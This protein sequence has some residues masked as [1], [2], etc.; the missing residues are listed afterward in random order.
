MRA[1]PLAVWGHRLSA[2]RLAAAARADCRLTH[3]NQSCQVSKRGKQAH[4]LL[5]AHG[6]GQSAAF[7]SAR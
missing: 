4:Q 7:S 2:E 1:S 5:H 6:A 3:P